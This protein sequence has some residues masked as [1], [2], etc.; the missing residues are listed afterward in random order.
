MKLAII[1]DLHFGFQWGLE[2]EPD[3]FIQA[4]KAFEKALGERPDAI[5]LL[6]DSFDSPIPRPEVIAR[7]AGIITQPHLSPK[8]QVQVV[9]LINKPAEGIK[10]RLACAGIPIIAIHGTHERRPKGQ[11]NPIEVLERLGIVIYLQA[12]GIIL[13]RE[14]VRVAIQGIGGV[15]ELFV[16]K[17][18]SI[19]D[20][21][22]VPGCYNVLMF[23]QAVRPYTYTSSEDAVLEVPLLPPGFD[24]YIDGHIHTGRIVEENGR[25][26]LLTGSTSMTQQKSEEFSEAKRIWILDLPHGTI[27]PHEITPPRPGRYL[28]ISVDGLSPSEIND[29]VMNEV[30]FALQG[31][32]GTKDAE[33]DVENVPKPIVRVKLSGK[34]AK[35]FTQ[36]NIHAS[37]IVNELRDK[38]IVSIEKSAV[39]DDETKTGEKQ[40]STVEAKQASLH[41][42]TMKLLSEDLEK[43]GASKGMID[44][45]ESLFTLLIERR[46]GD[47]SL[48]LEKIKELSSGDDDRKE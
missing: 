16:Q 22:P 39:M 35:G 18:F 47:D 6:G 13:E 37:D 5:L 48:I 25:K 1:G 45:V 14:G 17:V 29:R 11:A 28:E 43:N 24:L 2:R 42:T 31:V 23:H 20:P 30:N 12:N 19:W 7:A 4:R 33:I 26:L 27:T 38:V 3:S 41:E 46:D 15:P 9:K 10:S 32:T 8:S 36:S 34:I 21:K 44:E 40:D